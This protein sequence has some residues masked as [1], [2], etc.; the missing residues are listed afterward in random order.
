MLS[1]QS[2]CTYHQ[3]TKLLANLGFIYALKNSAD[4][5]IPPRLKAS[6][7]TTSTWEDSLNFSP[8]VDKTTLRLFFTMAARK[9]LF[10]RQADVVTA[11]FN[12][13]MPDTTGPRGLGIHRIDIASERKKCPF[14]TTPYASQSTGRQICSSEM[15]RT[16][17]G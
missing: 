9:N 17:E 5:K 4:P 16:Q 11:Y 13:D 15:E 14:N 12:A 7:T 2:L 1:G 6:L 10:M 3:V 8:V